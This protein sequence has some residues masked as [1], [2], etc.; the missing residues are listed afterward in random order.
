MLLE[1][2]RPTSLLLPIFSVYRVFYEAFLRPE[3]IMEQRVWD[4]LELLNL[5]RP[6]P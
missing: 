4:S 3:V 6:V 1:L 5:L 2:L